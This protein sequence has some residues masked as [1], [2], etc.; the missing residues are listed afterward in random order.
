MDTSNDFEDVSFTSNNET[1]F[2]NEE[3]E[4]VEV[5]DGVQ[6][7]LKRNARGW[8]H[9]TT[10]DSAEAASSWMLESEQAIWAKVKVPR[11]TEGGEVVEYRCNL[12]KKKGPQCLAA[13]Y[14]LYHS[15]NQGVSIFNSLQ[16]S[17]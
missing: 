17:K 5:E 12:V 9:E 4:E 11:N 13:V 6:A 14:L 1:E 7:G 2:R 16:K 8:T 3:D 15:T 10:F